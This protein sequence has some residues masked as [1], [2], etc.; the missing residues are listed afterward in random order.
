MD[1]HAV[2]D[3]ELQLELLKAIA[4]DSGL[5]LQGYSSSEEYI[6]YIECENYAPPKLTI[7]TDVRMPGKSGYELM[8]EIRKNRPEQRFVVITGT[9]NDHTSE[10]ERAC[11]YLT[12]PVSLHRLRKIF[13]TIGKCTECGNQPDSFKCEA[14]SDLSDFNIDDWSCPHK[15]TD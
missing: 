11:F 1:I 8:S 13:E 4:E 10:N 12:K 9:P 15:S 14:L 6:K 5:T 2:E 7:I 3:N